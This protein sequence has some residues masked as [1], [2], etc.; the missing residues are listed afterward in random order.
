[1]WCDDTNANSKWRFEMTTTIKRRWRA[2]VEWE[3][4]E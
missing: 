2:A 4:K 3:E 1:M